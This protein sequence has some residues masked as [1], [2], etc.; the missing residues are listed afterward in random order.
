[1]KKYLVVAFFLIGLV[2][3]QKPLGNPGPPTW[4]TLNGKRPAV[5]ARGGFSGLFPD[6]SRF[7]YEFVSQMSLPDTIFYCDLQLTK[8][9]VGFCQTELKLDNSTNIA[10]LFPQGQKTYN[11]NGKDVRG[12]FSIDYTADELLANVTSNAQSVLTR[13]NAFDGQQ[14]LLVE[15]VTGITKPPPPVWLNVQYEMFYNEHKISPALYL[16]DLRFAGISYISS[17]EIGFLKSIGAKVD[18]ARIKLVLRFLEPEAIEPTTKQA[19]GEILKDLAAIKPYASGILVPKTYIWPVSKELY[20]MPPTTLVADAHKEGLEVYAAGFANDSPGSYNYSYDPTAEY[21]QFIDNDQFSVDGVLTDFAPTASEAIACIAHTKDASLEKMDIPQADGGIIYFNFGFSGHPLII[22]HNGASG[23]YTGCTDLAYDKAVRDGADIIDCSVQMSKDGL[24]SALIQL[25][26][27][28]ILLPLPHSC[29]DLLLEIQSLKPQLAS[30]LSQDMG[31]LPRNPANKDKGKFLTLA[32]FLDFAKAK[33]VTGVLINIMNAP[34]LA[35]KKGLDI[36]GAVTKALSN[37]TFD[38]QSTQQVMIQSDDTSVLSKFKEV[39]SYQRIYDIKEIIGDT[40]KP[41]VDEIKKYADGVDLRRPSIWRS[42]SFFLTNFTKVVQEMHAANLSVHVSSLYN[43]YTTLAFDFFADPFIELATLIEELRVDAVVT[44]Y[45][46]TATTYFKSPC[47]DP[48]NTNLEFPISPA[49]P[50]ALIE[51]AAP[52]AL[53]P[54]GAPA[55][56][57]DAA[58][59]VAPPLPPVTKVESPAAPTPKDQKKS[60]S[61]RSTSTRI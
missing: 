36:V 58:S 49:E 1:M 7:A 61:E 27:W 46:A 34:Y 39:P 32:E 59:I 26:F 29:L 19:Y 16:E 10:V 44:D 48:T 28:E 30:P 24:H 43:E 23:D 31:G 51:L 12:W 20:L 45:P 54:S 3:A 42:R 53:P 17:P 15:D 56:T 50:G 47:S 60:A 5:I 55:P 33:A 40:P 2:T 8:D 9:G 14:L 41:T 37:A 35:S 18:K 57:L 52:Q 4:L 38:K 11:V 25:I 22:S 6:S 13:P 21:L